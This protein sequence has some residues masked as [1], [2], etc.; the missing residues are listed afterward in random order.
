MFNSA[1]ELKKLC[2]MIDSAATIYEKK[3]AESENVIC[4]LQEKISAGEKLSDKEEADRYDAELYLSEL[5][6]DSSARGI[7]INTRTLKDI[8]EMLSLA[9]TIVEK[10]KK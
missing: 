3:K 7:L 10:H 8:D 1:E 2:H 6:L 5:D 4:A 9:R